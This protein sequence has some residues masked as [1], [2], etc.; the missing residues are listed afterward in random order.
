M[1][2]SC[3]NGEG[4]DGNSDRANRAVS[5]SK[6]LFNREKIAGTAVERRSNS[7]NGAAESNKRENRE[8]VIRLQ[9]LRANDWWGWE[10]DLF[11]DMIPRHFELRAGWV[12][13]TDGVDR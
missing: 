4:I 3:E 9:V 5:K 8:N 12:G 11:R 7:S 10:V 2:G 1:P 6:C 13:S